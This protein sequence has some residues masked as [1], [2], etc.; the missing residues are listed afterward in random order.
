M[1]IVVGPESAS[2][3]GE[4]WRKNYEIETGSIDTCSSVRTRNGGCARQRYEEHDEERDEGRRPGRPAEGSQDLAGESPRDRPEE[5]AGRKGREQR[6]G[7]RAWETDLLV[8][9]Q[10]VEARCDGSERRRHH[11]Q[12]RRRRSRVVEDGSGREGQRTE[13]KSEHHQALMPGTFL[14]PS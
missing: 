5:G 8:R 10:D 1:F 12:G 13:G 4:A 6:T 3:R 7:A 11:R 2:L 9:H 14:P